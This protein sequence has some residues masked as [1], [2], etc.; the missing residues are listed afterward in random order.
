MLCVAGVALVLTGVLSCAGVIPS[1]A[2]AAIGV[3]RWQRV[4]GAGAVRVVR[5]RADRG[6]A[7]G[8]RQLRLLDVVQGL[9]RR[10]Q[11]L[12]GH[13]TSDADYD[14][15]GNA[16]QYSE[17][18]TLFWAKGANTV[19]FFKGTDVYAYLEGKS[20]LVRPPAG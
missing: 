15:C 14:H 17:N 2:G 20:Q 1:R 5:H 8:E 6:A 18:G 13:C 11:A 19:Y 4:W 3:M 16:M 9:R 12:I 10:E 7:E